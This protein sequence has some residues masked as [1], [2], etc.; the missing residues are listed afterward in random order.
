M[1]PAP[2]ALRA[3]YLSQLNISHLFCQ[4]TP[5]ILILPSGMEKP[6]QLPGRLRNFDLFF[7]KY[8][9][10]MPTGIQVEAIHLGQHDRKTRT[11]RIFR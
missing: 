1:Q 8:H 3:I 4:Y 5:L 9:S 10:S 11:M 7:Q 2:Q 6:A